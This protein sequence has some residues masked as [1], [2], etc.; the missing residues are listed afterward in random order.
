MSS[1]N[2]PTHIKPDP[3][4]PLLDEKYRTKIIEDL[5]AIREPRPVLVVAQE[6]AFPGRDL[7]YQFLRSPPYSLSCDADDCMGSIDIS[8]KVASFTESVKAGGESIQ[9]FVS[10]CRK[11]I[12]FSSKAPKEF[13]RQNSK[14]CRMPMPF[15]LIWLT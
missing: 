3:A 7:R 1:T 12:S 2:V 8:E 15:F 4:K 10:H 9:R 11:Q 6:Y 13:T 14:V 5:A